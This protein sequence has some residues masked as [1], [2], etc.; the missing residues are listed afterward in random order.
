VFA[1]LWRDST[2]VVIAGL[3]VF[4]NTFVAVSSGLAVVDTTHGH[5]FE[6]LGASRWQRL[7]RLQVPTALPFL[8][9]GLRLAVPAAV[10]GAVFG[11]WFGADRGI[12]ILLVVAMQN[13]RIDQLWAV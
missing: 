6:V 4:F 12:G 10:V 3:A 9:D 1:I 8:L 7:R 11:E 13:L 5:L 2:P